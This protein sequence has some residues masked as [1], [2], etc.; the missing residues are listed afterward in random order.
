MRGGRA[1]FCGVSYQ[2]TP[3]AL[4]SRCGSIR[5]VK[6]DYLSASEARPLYQAI[7]KPT[8]LA[9]I[10]PGSYEWCAQIATI[11]L[12]PCD[13]EELKP[14]LHGEYCVEVSIIA[15]GGRPFVEVSVQGYDEVDV[16][17]LLGALGALWP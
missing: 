11:L 9:P 10:C 6:Y 3:I 1:F 16:E 15:W 5:T 13:A 4:V 17:A 14:R 7:T 8:R 2:G 12:S